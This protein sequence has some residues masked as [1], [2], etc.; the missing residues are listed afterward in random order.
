MCACEPETFVSLARD[1]A[2]WEFEIFLMIIFDGI[3][4]AIAWPLVKKHWQH[5]IA[6]DRREALEAEKEQQS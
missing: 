6:R 5:H 4:G 3:V 1:L 2:H